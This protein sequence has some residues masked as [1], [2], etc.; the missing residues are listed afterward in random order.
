MSLK[1]ASGCSAAP[2]TCK[3]SPAERAT[4]HFAG[5]GWDRGGLFPDA[6]AWGRHVEAFA[7]RLAS[8]PEGRIPSG[9]RPA[10]RGNGDVRLVLGPKEPA[11]AR[12]F[13]LR[14]EGVAG[15]RLAVELEPL[16]G[17]A[18]ASSPPA[19]A[20]EPAPPDGVERQ[21]ESRVEG[22]MW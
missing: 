14:P 22:R 6:E 13:L 2:S 3:A 19:R 17:P 10:G 9:A 16:R 11:R 21:V 15:H 12:T 7:R 8:P 5:S 20:G 18:R 4:S 1:S